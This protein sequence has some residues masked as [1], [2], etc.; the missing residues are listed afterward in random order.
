M[1]RRMA[2]QA[3]V[4][5]NLA[6]NLIAPV[7][8]RLLPD[9]VVLGMDG[10]IGEVLRSLNGFLPGLRSLE[11]DSV[12][13]L[14]VLELGPG[15]TPH[16]MVAL[17]LAGARSC[18]GLDVSVS[19]LP[20]G[21][22][23]PASYGELAERLTSVD[24]AAY[25]DALGLTAGSI[26]ER[27]ASLERGSWPVRIERY[28]GASIALADASVDLILSKSVLEHVTP[29]RV[30]PLIG[31]MHR[32]LRPGGVMLHRIDLRDHM[33]IEGDDAVRGDWLD[34]LRYPEWLFRAMFSRRSTS[35]NRLRSSEWRR[36]IDASSWSVTL[37]DEMR[38]ALPAGF[39]RSK[40]ARRW[41]ELAPEELEIGQILVAARRAGGQP[42]D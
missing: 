27:L 18:I 9:R 42:P 1:S 14:D 36:L 30:L 20:S 25:R 39:D 15:R 24:G 3:Y 26:H 13:R 19:F 37:W 40:L 32:I 17:A 21:W 29:V 33:G 28:D 35:I 2:S 38:F 12:S 16:L 5:A 34:A 8:Q 6:K 23:S 11:L 7:A 22:D 31:E 41:R 10:D 4:G